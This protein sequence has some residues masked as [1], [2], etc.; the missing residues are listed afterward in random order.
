MKPKLFRNLPTNW[1]IV[2]P[3][4][5]LIIYNLPSKVQVRVSKLHHGLSQV[6]NI[7][8][9]DAWSFNLFDYR[10]GVS[11]EGKVDILSSKV[12]NFS[13][14]EV[15]KFELQMITSYDCIFFS[16]G[17]YYAVLGND[18]YVEKWRRGI[19]WLDLLQKCHHVHV[20]QLLMIS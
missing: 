9:T 14:I 20:L 2:E 19:L 4:N 17:K 12:A 15:A 10:M 13:I 8:K 18:F 5:D 16:E 11:L 7:C 3:N 6:D 1:V